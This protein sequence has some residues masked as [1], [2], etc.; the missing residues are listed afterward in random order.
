MRRIVFFSLF[1]L[2]CAPTVF[3]DPPSLGGCQIFPPTTR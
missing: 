2:I 1:V 3:A